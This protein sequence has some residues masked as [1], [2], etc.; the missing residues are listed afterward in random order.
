[1]FIALFINLVLFINTPILLGIYTYLSVKY[2][3]Y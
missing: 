1:M 3:W 2:K